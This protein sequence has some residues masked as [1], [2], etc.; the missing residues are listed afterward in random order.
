MGSARAKKDFLKAVLGGDIRRHVLQGAGVLAGGRDGEG[1][2][3]GGQ[4]RGDR[5]GLTLPSR[6]A[7][8]GHARRQP[9]GV[10]G[11]PGIDVGQLHGGGAAVTGAGPVQGQGGG[12]ELDG[13]V[14]GLLV[15]GHLQQ[16][17][18]PFQHMLIPQL[19]TD[20]IGVGTA[21]GE[22]I[23]A[24]FAVLTEP[25]SDGVGRGLPGLVLRKAVRGVAGIS[26][27]KDGLESRQSVRPKHGGRRRGGVGGAVGVARIMLDAVAH[28]A[29]GFYPMLRRVQ[30]LP[31][32]P[33][34]IL[35]VVEGVVAFALDG[36]VLRESAVSRSM[37]HGDERKQAEQ[38]QAECKDTGD[39][40]VH[41]S[42]S[43]LL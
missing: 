9:G 20:L 4:R 24:G 19:R 30:V 37:A 16:L 35:Q 15:P 42:L 38:A 26:V 31:L 39:G 13:V 23:A 8:E 25:E 7:G 18:R 12:R 36:H 11:V 32:A 27:H 41:F 14:Q 17:V 6:E 10:Q 40:S 5:Q 22:R 28:L 29:G 43:F 34:V 1:L 33:G 3:S 21:V 2:T